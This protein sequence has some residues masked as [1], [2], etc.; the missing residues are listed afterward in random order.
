MHSVGLMQ[1]VRCLKL[2][3]ASPGEWISSQETTPWLC[4]SSFYFIFVFFFWREVTCQ[5]FL[6][7]FFN[8]RTCVRR[9]N[10]A[11]RVWVLQEA[12]FLAF[13]RIYESLVD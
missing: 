9:N 1:S 2:S 11:L 10:M 5:W 12:Y 13:P 3:L 7:V 6:N 8:R 4:H